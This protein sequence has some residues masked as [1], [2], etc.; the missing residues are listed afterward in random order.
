LQQTLLDGM[1]ALHRKEPDALGADAGRLRRLSLPRLQTALAL[2]AIDALLEQGRLTRTGAFL[3]LP[4]HEV[5]LGDAERKIAE[6]LLPKIA[7]G[8]FDPP[9]VR[10]LAQDTGLSE[11]I[12][13]TTLLRGSPSAAT[14]S[15]SS[16]TCTT[17]ARWSPNW[18]RWPTDLPTSKGRCGRPTSG[19]RPD[20][21]ASARSR[22]WSSWTG[23]ASC[24]ASVTSTWPRTDS[25]M[26]Q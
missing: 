8:R 12:V 13:R 15:R 17:Q 22:C 25:T 14:C 2:R 20:S 9:W 5:K 23:S 26:F 16:G 11:A 3:H 6:R 24:A 4:E 19:M 7:E 10:D 21:D 1:A 18:R